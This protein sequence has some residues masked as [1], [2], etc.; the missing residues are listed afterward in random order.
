MILVKFRSVHQFATH[1]LEL[2][3][4]LTFQ[5]K[6]LVG[7]FIRLILFL[8]KL[9]LEVFFEKLKASLVLKLTLKIRGVGFGCFFKRLKVTLKFLVLSFD[10]PKTGD[11]GRGLD[12]PT[13]K[14]YGFG[15]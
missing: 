8:P 9:R 11:R 14:R 2:D 12:W 13:S 7:D 4:G 3:I 6:P 10:F 5:L 1:A 15:L